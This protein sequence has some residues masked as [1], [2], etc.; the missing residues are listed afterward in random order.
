VLVLGVG[1]CS[2]DGGDDTAS[3]A[4]APADASTDEGGEG[5][6]GGDGG[7]ESGT[8]DV[9]TYNVAGLPQEISDENPSE[10]MQLISPLLS[11]YDLVLLQESFDWWPPGGLVESL[12]LDA[13]SYVERLRA[14]ADLPYALPPHPGPDAAGIDPADRP[15]LQLGDGIGIMSRLELADPVRQ[16]WV[17]CFGGF[18]TSDGGAA[19]CLAIKGF[20]VATVELGGV[21]VDVYSLH[22]E[23]GG[24]DADQALQVDDFTQLA[25]FIEEH[26]EGRP[27][28]LGGDTNLHTDPEHPDAEGQAD[29]EIWEGFLEATGL[30]DACAETDCD[31]VGS[32]DK[33]ALRS[34]DDLSLA[35]T[36]YDQPTETF[37]S[38]TGDDLSDHPPVAV[39]VEWTRP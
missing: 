11:D 36:S 23:A 12:D 27:I 25:A 5:G 30:S 31:E 35:A 7:E 21:E 10:H 39:T 1:A 13:Q 6:A 15:D 26:S 34:T 33:V 20:A 38:P 9:L 4:D 16:A 2:D 22:G 32:I 19:D 37:T 3:D 17:G 29:T 8:V 28:I 14:D 24:T 18:D